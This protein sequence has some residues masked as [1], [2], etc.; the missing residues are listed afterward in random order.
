DPA[1]SC[2]PS[3]SLGQFGVRRSDS[4]I[5][6]GWA[7]RV[8][9]LRLGSS[10]WAPRVQL[11]QPASPWRLGCTGSTARSARLAPLL[12]PC[13]PSGVT[14]SCP[15]RRCRRLRPC[16]REPDRYRRVPPP[17]GPRS[18]AG[19]APHPDGCPCTCAGGAR[20]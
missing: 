15:A 8:G 11:V 7:P 10:G 6:P 2:P 18:T 3:S 20:A 19:G 17:G 12:H 9:L 16:R 5:S 13:P 4:L 14:M 1:E